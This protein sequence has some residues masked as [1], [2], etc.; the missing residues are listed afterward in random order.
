MGWLAIV[1]GIGLLLVGFYYHSKY[2]AY[3]RKPVVYTVYAVSLL[4]LLVGI[5]VLYRTN[6][7]PDFSTVAEI[8]YEEWIPELEKSCELNREKRVAILPIFVEGKGENKDEEMLLASLES[9]FSRQVL[10]VERRRLK[11]VLSE[12]SL[13]QGEIFDPSTAAQ[14]GKFLGANYVVVGE[15]K[16]SGDKIQFLSLR[17]VNV[18]TAAFC[19]K[20]FTVVCNLLKGCRSY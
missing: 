4:F 18:E 2:E 7:F 1:I 9:I 6:N 3:A 10:V 17:L 19:G 16:L 11:S 5:F 8:V 20:S 12:L 13:Q 14:V 15:G